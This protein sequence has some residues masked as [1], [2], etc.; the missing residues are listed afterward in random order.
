MAVSNTSRHPGPF[1]SAR[2]TRFD[3]APYATPLCGNAAL[4]TMPNAHYVKP[5]SVDYFEIDYVHRGSLTFHL[6]GQSPM[7]I[8]GGDV[9]IL[10]P[11]TVHRCEHD[12]MAHC[13]YIVLC[14]EPSP[15]LPCPPFEAGELAAIM[16]IFRDSGNRVVRACVETDAAFVELRNA[17]LASPEERNAPWYNGWLRNLMHRV[18]LCVVRSLGTPVRAP[19]YPSVERAKH[20]LEQSLTTPTK[21]SQ[22]ARAVGLNPARLASLFQKATGQTP[23][24]YRMRLRVEAAAREL[25]DTHLSITEVAARFSFASSQHFSLCFK[26]YLGVTPTAWR[27][28]PELGTAHGRLT[29]EPRQKD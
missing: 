17:S 27:R 26:K 22:I 11:R 1:G 25:R 5:H 6:S 23:A 29:T 21:I 7:H 20:L 14:V 15:Q 24:D 8:H 28:A 16:R 19:H 13:A 2:T 3:L 18:V 4:W 9:S 10:Q 12:T